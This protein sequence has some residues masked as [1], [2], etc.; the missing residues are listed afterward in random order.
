MANQPAPHEPQGNGESRVSRRQL[1]QY[2]GLAAA[3]VGGSSLLAA[4]GGDDGDG[5]GGGG[6]GAQSSGGV[7][8]HGATGGSTKDTLDPHGPVQ[9]ADIARCSNLYEPLLFWDN[10]YE[11]APAIAESVEPSKDAK[12]WTVKLREGVD[13]PQ[14]QGRDAGGRAVHDPARGGPEGAHLG[15]QHPVADHRLRRDQ[16]A[17]RHLAPDRRQDPLRDPRHP[18]G[19]VHLRDHPGGLRHQQPGRHRR[20]S[21]TCR[22]TRAR[23]ASSRSTP[24]T[25]ESRPSSTSCRSRTSRTTTRRSTRCT[26]GQVQ[27]IDNLPTNLIDSLK[28]QGGTALIADTGA[29]VPFTMRVDSEPFSD[30]RVR[31]AMRLHRATGSR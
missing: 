16:E 28:A 7:L 15:G 17:G 27:T 8:I 25:G 19:R 13:L 9:A 1:F 21:R 24:T 18:A 23:P 5:G 29:W 22:S 10:N 4:C 11:L 30:V 12:T 31:Q 20:R 14:R 6:S 26:A 2:S 3:A